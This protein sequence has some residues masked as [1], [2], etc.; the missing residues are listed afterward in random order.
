MPVI[1]PERSQLGN[2]ELELPIYFPSVSSVKTILAPLEYIKL[3]N[4]LGS[5]SPQFLVSAFDLGNASD[6]EQEKYGLLL[7]NALDSGSILLMDSGNFESYWK[8]ST[9]K[10]SRNHFHD[11]IIEFPCP[12]AFGF[13]EQKPPADYS[14]HLKLIVEGWQEDQIAAGEKTII[15]IIHGRGDN[16]PDLCVDIAIN[17][18]VDMV[19]V[20]ER[21]LGEGIFERILTVSAIRQRFKETG[22]Y[23]LLHLLGTG[24]PISIAAYSLAGADSF[25]GLECCQTVVDHETGLL[26]H[27]SQSDFF[28]GQT[29]WGDEEISFQARTLAHNLEFYFDWMSRLRLAIH[30][31]DGVAFCQANLSPRIF[32]HLSA[33][34]KWENPK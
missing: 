25:D 4:A 7:S 2:V 15:P 3:L 6:V 29:V 32:D 18:G 26:F 17:T 8:E 14:E 28:R 5:V 23:I 34:M 21:N 11:A 10:W 20:P 22:K 9:D 1:R 24:N 31:N 19:A 33:I 30:A 12:L 16:L 27:F 13:D